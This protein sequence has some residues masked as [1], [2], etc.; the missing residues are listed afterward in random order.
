MSSN[1]DSLRAARVAAERRRPPARTDAAA[2]TTLHG[3][4]T[5]ARRARHGPMP[6]WPVGDL[7]LIDCGDGRRLERFGDV[8]RRPARHRRAVMPRRLAA[9][10]WR[11]AAAALDRRARW[12]R[13]G[14]Q[15]RLDRRRRPASQL[16]CRP[17]A[18]GQVGLFPEHAATWGWLD[19][20]RARPPAP[21]SS[22][23]RSSSRCSATP[24]ARRS[25]AP[26]PAPGSPTWTR[27]SRRSPGRAGTRRLSGPR[28]PAGPLARRRRAR[29]RPPRAPPRAAATTASSST[30]R[31]TG[32]AP[33]P[34]KIETDLA[35]AARRPRG[36]ARARARP[37][38]L[39]SAH[40]PGLRRR[41]PRRAVSRAP[42]ASPSTGRDAADRRAAATSC[43]SAAG[44]ARPAR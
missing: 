31:R 18:G 17:A 13:G 25:P 24:A 26:A 42:R 22:G 3:S 39:L 10:E 8:R 15:T 28:R 7:E 33:A 20:R 9:A 38:S 6:P 12:A 1:G 44:R 27:R 23:R 36:A 11:R 41:A 16:E 37:S 14:D 40:T 5:W 34:W 43:A 2:S 35:A 19:G 21:R 30:R 32:T 4:G 29:V